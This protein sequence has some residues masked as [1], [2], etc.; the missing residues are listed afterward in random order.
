MKNNDKIDITDIVKKKLRRLRRDHL[1]D[2]SVFDNIPTYKR[3]AFR[4]AISRLA[5]DGVIV[6]V[7]SGKF[8]KRGDREW[9]IPKE[10]LR[11][12]PRKREWIKKGS[13]PSSY[14]KSALSSNLF[15]SNPTGSISIETIISAII[16]NNAL[17]DLDF[18]RFA[19]GDE[20]VIEVFLRDF[21]IHSRPIIRDILYV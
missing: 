8:Y 21:D 11:I 3:V 12:V 10:L 15:W 7:G 6:K 16:A 4:K 13:V 18:A 1:Y 20:R 5:K 2:Y 19:F 14:L 9:S 17:S